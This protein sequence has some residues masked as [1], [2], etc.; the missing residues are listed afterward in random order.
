M[1]IIEVHANTWKSI[2]VHGIQ[3]KSMYMHD[4]LDIH[5]NRWEPLRIKGN[6]QMQMKIGATQWKSITL[7]EHQCCQQES[8]EFREQQ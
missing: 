8:M 4:L 2:I 5:E 7:N 3:F 1:A 6:Q